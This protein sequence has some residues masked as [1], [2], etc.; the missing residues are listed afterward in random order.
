VF[1]LLD[2][3]APSRLLSGLPEGVEIEKLSLAEAIQSVRAFLQ[4][5]GLADPG[6]HQ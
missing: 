6:R 3:R 1:V 5:P 2:P 4:A